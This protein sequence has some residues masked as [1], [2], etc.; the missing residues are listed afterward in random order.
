MPQTRN[1]QDSD[2]FLSP[3]TTFKSTN[4][5]FVD[6]SIFAAIDTTAE[7]LKQMMDLSKRAC[8][9]FYQ[10]ACGKYQEKHPILPQ[11]MAQFHS[12]ERQ[13]NLIKMTIGNFGS[14][15]QRILITTKNLFKNRFVISQEVLQKFCIAQ[16]FF[17]CGNT[18]A[19]ILRAH[20]TEVIR[21]AREEKNNDGSDTDSSAQG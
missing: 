8:N 19:L 11:N 14:K 15:V 5:P 13:D 3:T 17:A 16:P 6:L 1:K 7:M 9:D 20:V 10:F 18:V 21:S 2:N 4:H 12:T